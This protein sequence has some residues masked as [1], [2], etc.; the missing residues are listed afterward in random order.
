MNESPEVYFKVPQNLKEKIDE[1]HDFVL[2]MKDNIASQYQ[3]WFKI[4]EAAQ[5][6]RISRS[7]LTTTL[8]EQIKPS[9]VGKSV[10]YD[11]VDMDAYLES[12]KN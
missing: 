12:K 9:R 5:Y 10:V 8:K 3:R 4:K 2:K 6:M 1:T 11:R 7:T